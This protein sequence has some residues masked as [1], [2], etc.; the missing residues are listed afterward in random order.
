MTHEAQRYSYRFFCP[1]CNAELLG[2]SIY[3][4]LDQS[5]KPP[6]GHLRYD[7]PV[8]GGR[9]DAPDDIV[10]EKYLVSEKNE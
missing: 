5:V 6:C 4:K 2:D 7:C 8:C 1:E 3:M 9:G 10:T